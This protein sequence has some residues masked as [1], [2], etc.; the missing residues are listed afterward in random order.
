M[1]E[2]H[3]SMP[4]LR[5]K[6]EIMECKKC[7]IL[8]EEGQ[9]L[10]PECGEPVKEK[11]PR[12]P[13]GK[14]AIISII[15][16]AL[17]VVL[18]ASAVATALFTLEPWKNDIN[19]KKSYV[20]SEF[21]SDLTAEWVVATMGDYELTNSRLQ[22]FFWMQVY[23]LMEYYSQ[24]Y[25]NYA[26]YYLNLDPSKPLSE[27]VY[28]EETGMTWEQYF[29]EEALFSWHRYQALT[30]EAKKAGFQMPEEYQKDFAELYTTLEESAKE[31]KFDSVDA[32]IQADMGTGVTFDDYYYYMELYYMGNLYFTEVTSK[33]TFTDAELDAY[34][35]ENKEELAQYNVSKDS[36]NLVD[37]RNILVKPVAS[38][39]DDGKTVYTEQAWA[40]CQAKAQEILKTWES[41]EK[42]EDSFGKLATDKSED[43]TSASNGGLY[44]Y[45]ARNELATVDVRHILIMPEGGTKD[46]NGNT[47]YSETEWETCR[48]TAQALLDQYLAGEKT[49]EAFGALANEHSDDNNGNVTNGGL[50]T[51]VSSGQMVAE[52]DE[53]IFDT[54][55]KTGDTG[56]VKTKFGYHVMYFV[57][58]DG[59]VDEWLFAE[60]REAGNTSIIKTDAGYEILY[61]VSSEAEW[62]AYSREGLLQK[63]SEELMQSYADARPME[64]RYWAIMFSE[65][66]ETEK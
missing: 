13:L 26:S 42:T 38:K 53:W 60:G 36:G 43:K 1:V 9:T 37:Y 4:R 58:R 11:K 57:D 20:V 52:F 45:I 3:Y 33:L 64:A 59:P 18:L 50:Y 63:T 24:Q 6:E 51:G 25:G 66:P 21:W 12:K 30:D 28:D 23:D 8:L 61:H 65:L 29:L 48:A 27:Q 47:T 35:E 55:R 34:F 56:L 19:N 14:K 32:M 54:S 2:F 40:D 15:C 49:A 62:K 39:D 5:E 10:C 31:A 17:V 16:V 44:R 22:V 46:E 41:G 7:G